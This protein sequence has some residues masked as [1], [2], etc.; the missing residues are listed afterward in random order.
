MK[1]KLLSIVVLLGSAGLA[2]AQS[3]ANDP[4][5]PYNRAMFGFNEALDSAVLAPLARGYVNVVPELART[6]VSNVFG[7]FTDLW[8]A[9]NQLLQGKG[10]A[11]ATMTMRV[12]TNTLFGIGGLFDV[13]SDLGMERQSE[14]FGQ[15]LGRWGLPAGPYFVW[16]VLG[17]STIRD[18]AGRPLDMA[19]SPTR[20]TDHELTRYSIS[21][22]QLV[23][24]RASLLGATRVLDG[25]ALDKYTFIRDAYIA[26]RRNLVYDGDPP[27]EPAAPEPAPK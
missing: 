6:G 11:A 4:L 1:T 15:T 27:E 17:P 26:R 3:A 9:A 13:A 2:H 20:L 25:I 19:W 22:L 14:D 23:D 5:E 18:S 10:E 16:P 7:N 21:G 24:A 12:A 8:S